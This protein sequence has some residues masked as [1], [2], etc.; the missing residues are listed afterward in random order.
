MAFYDALVAPLGTHRGPRAPGRETLHAGQDHHR[1]HG[2]DSNVLMA[3]AQ[4]NGDRRNSTPHRIDSKPPELIAEKFGMVDYVR[5]V[6][7]G[8]KF[9]ANPSTGALRQMRKI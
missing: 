1:L 8:A 5:E 3:T 4:V 6:T 9:H 7:L 2:I